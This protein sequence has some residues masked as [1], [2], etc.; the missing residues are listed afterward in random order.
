[1]A[2]VGR[3]DSAACN[4]YAGLDLWHAQG[5][6][7]KGGHLCMPLLVRGGAIKSRLVSG[8]NGFFHGGQRGRAGVNERVVIGVGWRDQFGL[9]GQMLCE[10]PHALGRNAIATAL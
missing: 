5:L 1:M 9:A 4:A 10:L 6:F 2:E 8:A 3:A 7:E